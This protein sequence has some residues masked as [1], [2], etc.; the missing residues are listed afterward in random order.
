MQIL[1]KAKLLM[2]WR[3]T[4]NK[5]LHHIIRYFLA[6]A[7]REVDLIYCGNIEGTSKGENISNNVNYDPF[8][9]WVLKQIFNFDNFVIL[10]N[11]IIVFFI[12]PTTNLFFKLYSI[13][14]LC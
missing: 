13:L 12:S 4:G 7:D 6:N 8:P 9:D 1:P 10:Y 2:Y 5:L 14:V 3:L 11:T